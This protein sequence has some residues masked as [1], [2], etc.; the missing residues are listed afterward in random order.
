MHAK[1]RK[2]LCQLTTEQ[3]GDQEP[4]S[5]TRGPYAV[6][7]EHQQSN[8]ASHRTG[9]SAQWRERALAHPRRPTAIGSA[10]RS[11][12]VFCLAAVQYLFTRVP[13]TAKGKVYFKDSPTNGHGRSQIPLNA[14]SVWAVSAFILLLQRRIVVNIKSC[15]VASTGDWLLHSGLLPCGQPLKPL[16]GF[17]VGEPAIMLRQNTPI[18]LLNYSHVF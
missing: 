7:H 3:K 9:G 6:T 13:R 14:R 1:P 10:R 11:D 4:C 18:R 2:R 15:I 5:T 16:W 8:R 12:R 17:V